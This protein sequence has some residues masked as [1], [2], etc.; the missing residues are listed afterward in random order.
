MMGLKIMERLA[1]TVALSA[2]RPAA[3]TAVPAV[4]AD[5]VVRRLVIPPVCAVR[6]D[7]AVM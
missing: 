3:I 4:A 5:Y 2:L 7:R 6:R 1:L